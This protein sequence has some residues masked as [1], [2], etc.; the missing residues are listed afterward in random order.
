M[1]VRL[2]HLLLLAACALFAPAAAALE[3]AVVLSSKSGAYAQ[4]AAALNAAGARNGHR[5]AAAGNLEDGIV[6]AVVARA[7]LV[8]AAG[9]GAA[10]EV[11][12]RFG[13]PTL[14]VLLAER[15]VADLQQRHPAGRLGALVL[16]QPPQRHVALVSAVAPQARRLGILIGPDTLAQ[17]ARLGASAAE[18]GLTL[19]AQ[20]VSTANELLP[21]LERVLESSDAL[22]TLPDAVASSPA[23]ARP[24]LLTSYR[25]RRPVFAYSRAYVDAGA[26][27]AVFST[28]EDV[29]RDVADWLARQ[30]DSPPRLPAMQTPEHFSI[31]VNRQ[32]ARALGLDL[33]DDV[34]LQTRIRER[35]RP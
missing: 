18:G 23:S 35:K 15:Q 9:P 29:A 6:D 16:D 14:A 25:F 4:F 17:E 11:L 20:R 26:L 31:A 19:S 5:L 8:I 33:P 32:V 2:R 12:R 21:A 1:L 28:P 7:D 3:V 22:L 34:T 24:I 27:A 30:P 10:D 13:R